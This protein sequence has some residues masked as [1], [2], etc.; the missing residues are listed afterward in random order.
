MFIPNFMM[1]SAGQ[2]F[3]F[4][5]GQS[6]SKI[7]EEFNEPID[8]IY[9]ALFTFASVPFFGVIA[10]FMII[11]RALMEN[12]IFLALL[13]TYTT[14]L[15]LFQYHFYDMGL[16]FK[17]F[18]GLDSFSHFNEKKIRQMQGIGPFIPDNPYSNIFSNYFK[19]H[20]QMYQNMFNNGS[21]HERKQLLKFLLENAGDNNPEASQQIQELKQLLQQNN[22]QSNDD[23]ISNLSNAGTIQQQNDMISWLLDNIKPGA[24]IN[25]MSMQNLRRQA[26]GLVNL[27]QNSL[28]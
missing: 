25:D 13:T 17:T 9:M 4:F 19:T 22:I 18:Y 20:K 10:D 6:G 26:Q 8:L 27:R 15:S 3:T 12:K 24:N 2:L 1:Q 7:F 16:I 5:T 23:S 11:V 28:Y 21:E 14:F